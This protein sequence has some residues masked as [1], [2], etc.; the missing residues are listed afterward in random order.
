MKLHLNTDMCHEKSQNLA[1]RLT[2]LILV[3]LAF[4][5]VVKVL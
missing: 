3:T 1:G 5:I 2:L 4:L